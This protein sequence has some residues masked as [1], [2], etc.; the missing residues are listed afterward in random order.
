MERRIHAVGAVVERPVL[1]LSGGALRSPGTSS[2]QRKADIGTLPRVKRRLR[3]VER[4]N[5]DCPPDGPS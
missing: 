3:G 2:P 4:T 5:G 1:T